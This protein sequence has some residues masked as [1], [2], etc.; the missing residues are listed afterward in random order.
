VAY[1]EGWPYDTGTDRSSPGSVVITVDDETSGPPRPIP[2]SFHPRKLL[3]FLLIVFAAMLVSRVIVVAVVNNGRATSAQLEGLRLDGRYY[4]VEKLCLAIDDDALEEGLKGSRLDRG[5]FSLLATGNGF[6]VSI[7]DGASLVSVRCGSQN[8]EYDT[9][10][11]VYFYFTALMY[12]GSPARKFD[13]RESEPG[14]KAEITD[15]D[16]FT[17]CRRDDG[18]EISHR[19]VDDNAEF[20]CQ[21]KSQDE[22]LLPALERVMRSEC[23]DLMD[24]LA[25]SRPIPYLGNGFLTVL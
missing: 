6:D 9:D 7:G 14:Q 19:I 21:V 12:E 24:E 22:T 8:W 20:T 1:L 23:V 18:F 10:P 11:Q 3:V 13:C 2:F 4:P 15:V 5:T 17:S 16:G 25:D